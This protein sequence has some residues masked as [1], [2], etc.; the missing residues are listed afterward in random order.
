MAT[1]SDLYMGD[2]ETCG[3]QLENWEWYEDDLRF[4]TTCTCG[5]E[6]MLEPTMG[7]LECDS[8]SSIEDEDEED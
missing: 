1:F 5:C 4:R 3:T 6:Y 8:P 7:A 2:C